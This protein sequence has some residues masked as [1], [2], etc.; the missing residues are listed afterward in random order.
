MPEISKIGDIAKAL[1]TPAEELMTL[2][3]GAE[4]PDDKAKKTG[5]ADEAYF[6]LADKTRVGDLY[7]LAPN[8]SKSVL[9]LAIDT[10]ISAKGAAAATM[11]FRF[12]DREYLSELGTTLFSNGDM[13]LAEYVDEATLQ[14]AVVDLISRDP[15][16]RTLF[17]QVGQLLTYCKDWEFVNNIF[18]HFISC[19][20][21]WNNWRG[22][23]SRFPSEAVVSQG[24]KMAVTY[25]PNCFNSWWDVVGRRNIAKIFIGYI[26]NYEKNNFRAWQ[27]VSYFYSNADD[28]IMEKYIKEC[29]EDPETDPK[30][31][32]PFVDKVSNELRKVLEAK[33]VSSPKQPLHRGTYGNKFNRFMGDNGFNSSGYSMDGALGAIIINKLE[34]MCDSIVELNERIDDLESRIDDLESRI[35]DLE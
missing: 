3:Y 32:V 1:G 4:Q 11:L 6:A 21:Y 19:H 14:S 20:R 35:D 9:E 29:L 25:G 13:R 28:A 30:I 17:N 12:A 27:D 2:L 26:E 22:Y 16:M 33:G 31:F 24:V 8:L 5:T 18:E 34:E 15:E 10:L 7:A 23:I